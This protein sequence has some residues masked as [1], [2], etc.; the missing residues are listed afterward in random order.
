MSRLISQSLVAKLLAILIANRYKHW[1]C[2]IRRMPSSARLRNC[3]WSI[4]EIRRNFRNSRG[5]QKEAKKVGIPKN[6]RGRKKATERT[7]CTEYTMETY[8]DFHAVEK[9]DLTTMV[10]FW[11]GPTKFL[12]SWSLPDPFKNRLSSS[13]YLRNS[14]SL[15]SYLAGVL[16]E[17]ARFPLPLARLFSFSSLIL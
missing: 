3:S 7:R 13:S 9:V 8:I 12:D 2:I 17:P 15:V 14:S 16:L 1:R 11:R 5:C 10:C 4:N 6:Q